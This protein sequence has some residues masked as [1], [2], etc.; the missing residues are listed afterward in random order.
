MYDDLVEFLQESVTPFHA[1][2]TAESWLRA[3]GFTR[4]EEA[5]YWNLE[6]GKGYY[7]TRNGSSVVAW[8]VPQHAIGGWRIVAS[9]SDSPSW[10]IKADTVE[11]DGCRRLSVEGYGGMIMSTW[12]D[13]PLT[14]GGRALVKTEDGIESRLVYLDRDLL[15]IP[16][17][18]IHFQR[19]INKGH[20][21]NPQVDMQPLWGPAGSRTLTDLVAESLGVEAAD[22]LDSDLQLVTRQAPTQIGPDGEFFMA[23]RIDDLECAATTLLGFLDASGET[24]SA[25]APVWAMF[26]NEEVGSETKQGAAST[27]LADT[28]SRVNAALGFGPEEYVRALSASMLVSCDNAHA[29]HPAHPELADS[30]HAPQMNSGIVVK[31]AANQHYCTD[32]FSRAA[33]TAVLDDAEIPHQAFANRSDKA[34]G[35]TLGNISNMQVSVHGVDVGCAQLSMHSCMETAG[36]RDVDLAIEALTAFYDTNVRIDGADSI[37]LG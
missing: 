5:D 8:R 3:A 4:L 15:V 36:A 25:C 18:A 22:I 24:D 19:D 16:S 23:P 27:L 34:G 37:E 10:K 6:P 33:F 30:L 31:E 29:Q 13:R 17:L 1:A 35:S 21:F 12:L 26:D 20:T 2:A 7:T 28:L 14:V 32:A 9:H 11:N